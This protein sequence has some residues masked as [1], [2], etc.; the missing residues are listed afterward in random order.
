MG[1]DTSYT[2]MI[3]GCL[4]PMLQVVAATPQGAPQ[5]ILPPR[6][7]APSADALR[8][9]WDAPE[10]PNGVVKEYQ[11]RQAGK[12]LIHT[13]TADRRQH[14]V[15]GKTHRKSL[16][17]WGGGRASQGRVRDR[18]GHFERTR[19]LDIWSDPTYHT[20]RGTHTDSNKPQQQITS[21]IIYTWLGCAL[22]VGV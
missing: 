20:N 4:I 21:E 13:D 3:N 10:K 11:L 18:R 14:T 9:S 19:S 7:T 15:T 5:G 6:V 8:L 2:R 1:G 22:C 16:S 17:P 12:G